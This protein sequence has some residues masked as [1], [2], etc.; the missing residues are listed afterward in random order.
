[1]AAIPGYTQ[2]IVR[3][4]QVAD[5]VN[6][7]AIQEAAA[8]WNAVARGADLGAQVSLKI[9]EE[10][11]KATLNEMIISR[12]REKIDFIEGAK[13]QYEGTP[14]G[15]SGYVEKEMQKKDAAT[16]AALPSRLQQPFKMT[17]QRSN[18][19]DYEQNLGWE[20][21]RRV[22]VV[23]D[24]LGRAGKDISSLG[25]TYGASGKPFEELLPNIDATVYAGS[26]VIA[27]EKLTAFDEELRSNTAKQYLTGLMARDPQAAQD[28]INTGKFTKFL[29]PE[30]VVEMNK[31]IWNNTP[32][33]MKI[34]QIKT[35]QKGGSAEN[36]ALNT[37]MKNEGGYVAKDGASGQPAIYGIN[38]GA[39]PEAFNEAERITVEQGA[40]A[41]Q[42][43]AR[44]FYKKE[45]FDKNNIGDLNPQ[46]QTI[47]ADGMVNHWQGFKTKL[48][49][50]AK[51]GATP[52]QLLEMRRGEYERLAAANDKYK[53]SLQGWLKRLDS[54]PVNT[55]TAFDGMPYG[56]KINE[57]EKIQK[58][59]ADD[60]AK[61]AMMYGATTPQAIVGVQEGLGIKPQ[62]ARVL[63]NQQAVELAEQINQ[64]E[65]SDEIYQAAQSLEQNYGTYKFN[66]I[67][68]LKDKGKMKPAMEGALV[69]AATGN[70]VYKEH[71]EL[72][73]QVGKS[74]ADSI[75]ALYSTNGYNDKDLKAK[76]ADET[77]DWQRAVQ[78]EGRTP[79][80][81]QEKMGVAL[82]LAKAKMNK[83]LNGDYDAAVVFAAKPEADQYGIA[84]AGGTMF[85]V[86]STYSKDVV[87][88]AVSYAM[89]ATL[90]EM[91]K[92]STDENYVYSKTVSPFLSPD[93]DGIMFRTPMGEPVSGKDGKAIVFKFDQL[94]KQYEDK[95]KNDPRFY[96]RTDFGSGA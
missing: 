1:M 75:N 43:Y 70:P 58:N 81:I 49:Q 23:G 63:S 56:Q 31:T 44:Q 71:V 67:A 86:P 15:F 51:D 17:A 37:I 28:A 95:Q 7:G 36:L 60:P 77:M 40:A 46:V 5:T 48:L 84:E 35:A 52:Q 93:E 8:G 65:N 3:Q 39:H 57:M 88:D 27:P 30:G 20:T 24:K 45:Y 25:Y 79:E 47:V 96:I 22:A 54:L 82:S 9:Q 6:P 42:E 87:E 21:Q 13:K 64:V 76:L 94:L 80:E 72:L 92:G 69:L 66:A 14:D 38:R 85:R 11:D 62:N 18:L 91:V 12:E 53:P 41:G 90:P 50:A 29:T 73:A 78:N 59:I 33:L 19:S 26:G 16:L 68:D 61:A 55:G 10:D 34:E 2:G 4:A 74:G 32:D 83:S 89:S